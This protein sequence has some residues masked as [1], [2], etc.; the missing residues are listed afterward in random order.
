MTKILLLVLSL[1]LGS[2]I[3]AG[4]NT[5]A[6]AGEDISKGGQKIQQEAQEHKRY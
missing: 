3:L 4:C 6:G 2:A 1:S 5:V